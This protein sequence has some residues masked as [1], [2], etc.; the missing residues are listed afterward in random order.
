MID[1]L[2]LI[3]DH[4]FFRQLQ[5]LANIEWLANRWQKL[6]L[7]RLDDSRPHTRMLARKDLAMLYVQESE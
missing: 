1:V 2:N 4:F 3:A 7:H 6:L 5:H